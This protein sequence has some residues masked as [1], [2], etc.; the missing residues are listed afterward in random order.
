MTTSCDRG[1]VTGSL[2]ESKRSDQRAPH[3]PS[4]R[5]AAANQLGER[6]LHPP[7]VRELSADVHQLV[8]R[9]GAR[10]VTLRAVVEPQQASD[11]VKAEAE[12]LRRLHEPYARDVRR[13]V[14][15]DPPV[16]PVRLSQEPLPLI[17]PYGLD[18]HASRCGEAANGQCV[19]IRITHPLTP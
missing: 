15:P 16:V 1:R 8:F 11:L 19:P 9:R 7:E 2:S 4:S 18:M 6:R 12:S 17:E 10:L 13:P 14:T 5:R 3:A